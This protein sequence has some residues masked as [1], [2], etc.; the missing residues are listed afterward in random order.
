MYELGLVDGSGIISEPTVTYSISYLRW[1]F[2][3]GF[4]R[5]EPHSRKHLVNRNIWSKVQDWIDD[6]DGRDN[7]LLSLLRGSSWV[8]SR[9]IHFVSQESK[10][11]SGSVLVGFD[12]SSLPMSTN[13]RISFFS[14]ISSSRSASS[15]I[16]L[17]LSNLGSFIWPILTASWIIGSPYLQGWWFKD[18][19]SS[20]VLDTHRFRSKK[21]LVFHHSSSPS[22]PQFVIPETLKFFFFSF[23]LSKSKPLG[24]GP[25]PTGPWA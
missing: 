16:C 10:W 15:I 5:I 3:R 12:D 8:Y 11:H 17:F 6:S 20:L 9:I 22:Y 2:C 24:H 19:T 21:L 25:P 4:Q 23:F 18:T 13:F 14:S 7:N 1:K